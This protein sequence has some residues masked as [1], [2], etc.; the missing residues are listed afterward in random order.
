MRGFVIYRIPIQFNARP[1]RGVIR[2]KEIRTIDGEG[3]SPLDAAQWA[4]N[5]AS[6]RIGTRIANA[7]CQV[8]TVH[9]VEVRMD[10]F[11]DKL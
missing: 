3:N 10:L 11:E 8:F 1:Y 2:K 4:R 5:H 9:S 6:N 7:L